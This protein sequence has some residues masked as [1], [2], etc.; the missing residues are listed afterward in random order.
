MFVQN[1]LNRSQRDD[2][3]SS[4]RQA[5]FPN[6]W[7]RVSRPAHYVSRPARVQRETG[8]RVKVSDDRT[9]NLALRDAVRAKAVVPKAAEDDVLGVG[10]D[11]E[12]FVRL[13]SERTRKKSFRSVGRARSGSWSWNRSVDGWIHLEGE[14]VGSAPVVRHPVVSSE[15]SLTGNRDQ[16]VRN[17]KERWLVLLARD[18]KY[19]R[20]FK[21]IKWLIF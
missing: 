3:W 10:S 19:L 7:G 12:Q 11:D 16:A 1:Y 4:S 17:A 8:D 21:V 14:V 9:N 5:N 15:N 2:A 18:L 6:D 13:R 20:L